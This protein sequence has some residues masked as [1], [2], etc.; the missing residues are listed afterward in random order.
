MKWLVYKHTNNTSGKSYIGITKHTMEHR[1]SRHVSAARAGGSKSYHFQKAIAL[2]GEFDWAH[3]VLVDDI[4]TID[5]ANAFEKYYIKKY[6]TFESGYNST[7]GGDGTVG[8]TLTEEEKE[9]RN[10]KA[11]A[12]EFVHYEH[13]YVKATLRDM[14]NSYNVS[15]GTLH[16][17]T[18]GIRDSHKGWFMYSNVGDVVPDT[19]K[20]PPAEHTFYKGDES[21]RCTAKALAKLLGVRT[22]KV[23]ELVAGRSKH[24]KGWV[25]N[26]DIAHQPRKGVNSKSNR[27]FV[28][29]DTGEEFC[30]SISQLME[31]YPYITSDSNLSAVIKGRRKSHKGWTFI[32]DEEK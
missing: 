11:P 26:N 14:Y 4:G 5:E 13:G 25:T 23:T 6:D 3:E 10:S 9:A 24:V 30:G 18:T 15:K 28:N 22:S 17:V 16:M 32:K 20:A 21:T 1:W 19:R 7:Y 27:K 31:K 29:K 2:Y 12:Y 8:V